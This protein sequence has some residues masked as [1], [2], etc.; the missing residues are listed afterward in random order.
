[1]SYCIYKLT[2]ISNGLV[3][4]GSTKDYKTRIIS[5]E[6]KTNNVCSSKEI[7]E[8]THEILENNIPYKHIALIREGYYIRNFICINQVNPDGWFRKFKK[9]EHRQL[10]FKKDKEKMRKYWRIQNKKNI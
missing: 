6:H 1:M 7:G 5:H 4:Y 2:G 3:Y 8:F 9:E 10:I